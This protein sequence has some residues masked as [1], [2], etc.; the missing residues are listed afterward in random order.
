M[1]KPPPGRPVTVTTLR[2]TASQLARSTART[3]GIV[4]DRLRP[5]P[6][7]VVFLI[8]H[9]VGAPQPGVVNL[10]LGLFEQQMEEL[11]ASDRVVSI[12]DALGLLVAPTVPAGTPTA[13][14]PT[15]GTPTEAAPPASGADARQPCPVVLTFDDGT[16]DFV[17]HAVPV[18]QRLGL[19]AV[20]YVAT[21]WV[22]EGRSFWGDDTVLSWSGLAEAQASGVVTVGSHTHGHVHADATPVQEFI[23]D[24]DR[25]IDLIGSNLGTTPQHFAYPKALLPRP[26]VDAAVRSRFASAAIGG[27]RPNVPGEADPYALYRSPLQVG[28]AMAGFRRKANGGMHAEERIRS[29]AGS[30]RAKVAGGSPLGH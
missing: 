9:Q 20:L 26:E 24:L 23:D 3:V 25:S 10:P 12:D 21:R 14:T 13:G 28:D 16:A 1:S 30:V 17:D 22:D 5:P 6:H 18:L 2:R 4:S 15:A 29:L 7:G 19:P 27:C 11:A 8:Y